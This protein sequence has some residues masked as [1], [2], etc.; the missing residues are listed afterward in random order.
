MLHH[1]FLPFQFPVTSCWSLTFPKQLLS[2]LVFHR[3]SPDFLL[4]YILCPHLIVIKSTVKMLRCP[5]SAVI[6][7][8]KPLEANPL[9]TDLKRCL[10]TFSL[11]I[12]GY[13]QMLG[14]GLYVI[15]WILIHDMGGP[16]A[17]HCFLFSGIVSLLNAIFVMLNVPRG[18]QVLDP[19]MHTPIP[20]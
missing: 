5:I 13:G 9:R 10:T 16:S 15:I 19:F 4:L 2:L 20:M 3:R 17:F 6:N 7:R 8:K 11:T 1:E 12:F 18:Y 14:A